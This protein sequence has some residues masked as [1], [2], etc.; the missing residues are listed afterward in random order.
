MGAVAEAML[1]RLEDEV[2]FNIRDSSPN[3]GARH[4][5]GR[6]RRMHDGGRGL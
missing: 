2:T 3:Q 5:F 1:Q 6:K 4:L